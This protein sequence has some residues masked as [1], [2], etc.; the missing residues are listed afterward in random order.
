MRASLFSPAEDRKPWPKVNSSEW[1]KQQERDAREEKK[2][3]REMRICN[4]C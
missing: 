2:V 3:E 1:L 4:G